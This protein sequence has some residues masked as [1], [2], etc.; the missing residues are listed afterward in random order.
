MKMDEIKLLSLLLL[1]VSCS[2]LDE[3]EDDVSRYTD[4]YK[5]FNLTTEEKNTIDYLKDIL[6]SFKHFIPD[7]YKKDYKT[8]TSDEFYSLLNSFGKDGTK[9][10]A[11]SI[12]E[13]Q[14]A[15]EKAKGA[16]DKVQY[17]FEKSRLHE[18]LSRVWNEKFLKVV[19]NRPDQA[20]VLTDVI[21]IAKGELGNVKKIAEL[22]A[23]VFNKFNLTLDEKKAV[24][25]L[26]DALTV[27]GISPSNVAEVVY[28]DDEVYSVLLS[29]PFSASNIK[30]ALDSIVKTLR[31]VEATIVAV[32]KVQEDTKRNQL[33]ADIE[34][35]DNVYK[36]ELKRIFKD[37]TKAYNNLVGGAFANLSFD[38]KARLENLQAKI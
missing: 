13:I 11:E 23:E 2:L 35:N 14:K 8:Y 31:I 16:I 9:A 27:S 10:V 36:S 29:L 30:R 19:F 33:L 18:H 1:L 12:M 21:E 38:Y 25:Y 32:D 4:M 37:S 34:L 22:S 20:S 26:R 5:N 6:M 28:H 3:R 24:Y 15:L 17:E 7:A